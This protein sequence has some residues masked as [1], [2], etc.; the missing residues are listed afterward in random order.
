MKCPTEAHSLLHEAFGT[1]QELDCTHPPRTAAHLREM[2][3]TYEGLGRTLA[4]LALATHMSVERSPVIVVPPAQM[5][6]LPLLIT[7]SI[8]DRLLRLAIEAVTQE[9][10]PADGLQFANRLAAILS[11]NIGVEHVPYFGGNFFGRHC[12]TITSGCGEIVDS[13]LPLVSASRL[14]AY[15]CAWELWR[16]V[17]SILNRAALIPPAEQARFKDGARAFVSLLQGS[18]PWFRTSPKL[19]MLFAHSWEFMWLWGSTELYGEQAIDSWHCFYNQD[20]PR[21]TAETALLSYR[22]LEQKMALSGV[23]SEA[24]RRAKAP[25]RKGNAAP[26]GAL[27]PGDRRLRQKT[28]WRREC[29]ATLQKRIDNRAKWAKDQFEEGNGVIEAYA[30]N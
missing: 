20:A 26:R 30:E 7:I 5:V 27:R 28:T 13:L 23:A 19:H 22:K 24:L 2:Q 17:L 21:F 3:E 25:L 18:F 6:P 11:V 16:G 4:E 10:G 1:L 29:L 15:E 8:T 14:T 12:R 9:R